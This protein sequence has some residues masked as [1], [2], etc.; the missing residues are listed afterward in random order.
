MTMTTDVTT[1]TQAR[2]NLK[3]VFD[4]VC[5]SHEPTIITRKDGHH[6]VVMS[7]EDYRGWE[8]TNYLLKSPEN[9]K[10]LLAAIEK[11]RRGEHDRRFET[12]EAL[13]AELG[14]E[15]DEANT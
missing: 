14:I 1:Y 12:V 13:R 5:E 10:R 11:D 4:E 3:R 8:E 7:L 2:Q 9:A 15:G 6:V